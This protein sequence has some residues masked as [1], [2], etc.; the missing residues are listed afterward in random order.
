M[1]LPNFTGATLGYQVV[2]WGCIGASWWFQLKAI[3]WWTIQPVRSFSELIIFSAL[4]VSLVMLTSQIKMVAWPGAADLSHDLSFIFLFYS[5]LLLLLP[6]AVTVT[7]LNTPAGRA[8]LICMGVAIFIGYLPPDGINIPRNVPWREDYPL[9]QRTLIKL[10]RV[11]LI[12]GGV[13]AI[14]AGRGN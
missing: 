4:A 8:G 13:A 10:G 7:G 12:L 11:V 14:V 9:I 3:T 2:S 1:L 6:R 5:A